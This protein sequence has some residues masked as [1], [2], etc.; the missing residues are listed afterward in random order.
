MSIICR[1]YHHDELKRCF[2]NQKMTC[3]CYG[4]DDEKSPTAD[5][6]WGYLQCM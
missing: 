4:C 5:D 1:N 6:A 2:L 3:G